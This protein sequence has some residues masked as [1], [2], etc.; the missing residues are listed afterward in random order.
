M[1]TPRTR[2]PKV[3]YPPVWETFEWPNATVLSFDQS[4]A[5]TGWA[6]V[7]FSP[8]AKPLVRL[9]GT[10]HSKPIE[11]LSGWEDSLTRGVKISIGMHGIIGIASRHHG[12][13]HIVHEQ[14]AMMG[15]VKSRKQEG[16]GVAAM[17]V[18]LS[19]EFSKVLFDGEPLPMVMV[20]AVQAKKTVTGD[21]QADKDK[22][23]E[24]VFQ[25]VDCFRTNEHVVDAIALALTAAV[26]GRL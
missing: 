17:A 23:R 2:K 16:P 4:L 22:V 13:S 21:H 1:T 20:Q 5:N 26:R 7:K 12:I 10:I 3:T 11:G 6:V 24:H 9:Y 25:A 18:R 14:P 8:Y 19:A 15:M